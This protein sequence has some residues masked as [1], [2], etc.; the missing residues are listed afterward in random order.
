VQRTT[1]NDSK[2]VGERRD[3]RRAGGSGGGGGGGGSRGGGSIINLW[4]SELWEE[5]A[6]T[7]I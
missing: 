1:V 7:R 4:L 6:K 2:D 3:G 5:G